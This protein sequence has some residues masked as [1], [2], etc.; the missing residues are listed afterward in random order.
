MLVPLISYPCIQII[1]LT[2]SSSL[3]TGSRKRSPENLKSDNLPLLFNSQKSGGHSPRKR[4]TFTS[5]PREY[6]W[7][8]I[9]NKC[10]QWGSY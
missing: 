4:T 9:P 3:K 5:H 2:K 7:F 6:R 8:H 1:D 10:I